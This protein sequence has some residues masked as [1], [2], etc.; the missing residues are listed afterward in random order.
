[1]IEFDR[2]SKRTKMRVSIESGKFSNKEKA[3]FEGSY[4]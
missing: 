4:E 2:A 3:D 1:M